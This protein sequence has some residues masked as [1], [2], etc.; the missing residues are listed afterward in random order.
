MSVLVCTCGVSPMDPSP[1]CSNSHEVAG[2]ALV[3]TA[4]ARPKRKW[5]VP[6]AK[7]KAARPKRFRGRTAVEMDRH[8]VRVRVF[9]RIGLNAW[10][11]PYSD[12]C[13]S[14]PSSLS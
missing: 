11:H 13:E 5:L 2:V 4:P 1:G 3:S 8:G 7:P 14:C 12:R 10:T 6:D 9:H